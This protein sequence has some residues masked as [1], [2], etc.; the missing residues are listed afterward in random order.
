[1]HGLPRRPPLAM[2][3]LAFVISIATA[4]CATTA[5][6]AIPSPTASAASA[7]ATAATAPAS[8]LSAPIAASPPN[9]ELAA[10]GGDPTDGQLGTYVWRDSGSDSPWLPGAPI[11]VG[12]GEPLTVAFKPATNVATWT[13]RSVPSTADGPAGAT[14]LGEGAGQPRFQAPAAGTW[15]LEVHVVFADG[16]GNASYFW[17]L[18]VSS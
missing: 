17:Q 8:Q 11:A 10:E 16:L 9:A 15:T 3:R 13:A 18:A 14:V 6:P 5:G 2:A 12:S 7:T 1:M 4:A